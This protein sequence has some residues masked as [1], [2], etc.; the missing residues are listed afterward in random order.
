MAEFIANAIMNAR[1]TNGLEA[2]RAKYST[3][4]KR[5]RIYA[6]F[7]ET[8]DTILTTDGYSDCIVE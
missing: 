8:V 5:T 2:G 3:Y 7:R 1:D 6:R 4:F